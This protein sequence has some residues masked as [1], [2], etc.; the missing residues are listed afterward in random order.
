MCDRVQ[1]GR[2]EKVRGGRKP[3]AGTA[4]FDLDAVFGFGPED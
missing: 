2:R 1:R 3:A 4:W